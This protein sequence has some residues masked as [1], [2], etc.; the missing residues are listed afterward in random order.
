MSDG[1]GPLTDLNSTIQDLVTHKAVSK[2]KWEHQEAAN[3]NMDN[4]ITDVTKRLTAL[5]RKVIWMTGF[6]AAIGSGVG[7]IL[8]KFL[9]GG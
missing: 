1:S 9:S 8:I 7:S 2:V 4:Q 6:A 5:E 3:K